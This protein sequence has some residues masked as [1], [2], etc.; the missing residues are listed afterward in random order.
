MKD[1]NSESKDSFGWFRR[2]KKP[3]TSIKHLVPT[4]STNTG[5]ADILTRDLSSVMHRTTVNIYGGT[6]GRGGDGGNTGGSGGTGCGPTVRFMTPTEERLEKWL[7]SPPKMTGKQHET[8]KLRSQGTSEWFFEDEKFIE[9]KDKPGVLWIEG[10]SG[11]GKSV[12]R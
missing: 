11:A 3:A 6:G 8:E 1:S 10:P 2:R 7:E 12:L 9:W 4:T 5:S